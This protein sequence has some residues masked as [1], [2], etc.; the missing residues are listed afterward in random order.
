MAILVTKNISLLRSFDFF[1]LLVSINRMPLRGKEKAFGED[2]KRQQKAS[3]LKYDE[4]FEVSCKSKG[5]CGCQPLHGGGEAR[6]YR[7]SVT[8][9]FWNKTLPVKSCPLTIHT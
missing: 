8:V 7:I 3:I 2:A 4:G 5:L 9:P 6:G 1:S